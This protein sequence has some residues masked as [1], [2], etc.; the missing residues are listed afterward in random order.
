MP[1]LRVL[2]IVVCPLSRGS[3]GRMAGTGGILTVDTVD[4][5]GRS[6]GWRKGNRE[7]VEAVERGYK[8]RGSTTPYLFNTSPCLRISPLP[9]V[10]KVEG[11][12]YKPM[13]LY[14]R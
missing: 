10:S 11:T 7:A 4:E 5:A 13:G 12:G 2:N 14:D 6:R 8:Q 9:S 1:L 3:L